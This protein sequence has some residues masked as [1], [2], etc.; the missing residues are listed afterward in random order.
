ML[1]PS[2][3]N[4]PSLDGIDHCFETFG[5]YVLI[6]RHWSVVRTGV[7]DIA[8]FSWLHRVLEGGEVT[9]IVGFR[10]FYHGGKRLLMF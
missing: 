3:M 1:L 6:Q 4:G 9:M 5:I 7:S 10:D 8:C 2:I